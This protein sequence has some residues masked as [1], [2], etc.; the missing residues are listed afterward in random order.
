[1]GFKRRQADPVGVPSDPEQL[2]RLLARGNQGPAS[3]W[4]HQAKV[5]EHW[6]GQ[7]RAKSDVALEL[8]TGAGKTLV[9][10]LIAEYLRRTEGSRVAYLCP[11][12]QLAVQTARK[13]DDYGIPPS[14]LIG[15]S[16]EWDQADLARYQAAGS[17]AVSTYSHVFN[18]RPRIDTA[19]VLILDD[20]HAAEGYVSSPWSLRIKRRS[21]ESA[22]KDLLAALSP[23]LDP[24][25]LPHLQS[26]N[27]RGQYLTA[28]YLASPAA[29]AARAGHVESVIREAVAQNKV[30]DD[31]VYAWK[32]LETHVADCLA[33]VSYREILIRP[34]IAPTFQHSAFNSPKQRIYMSA[35]LGAGGE[36]ER[37]FGRPRIHRIPV[38]AGWD[39]EGTGRRFFVFPELAR[40]LTSD[41]TVVASFVQRVIAQA[42]RVVVLTPE[43]RVA[44][45][46]CE[47]YLPEDYRT[48]TA[49]EVE[50]DL[51]VFTSQP[52]AALVLTNRYDGVDLP[53]EDCRL[54]VFNGLP[55]NGDLQEKFLHD[56][57]GAEEVLRERIRARIQQGA[58]RATRNLRDHAA[59]LVL[60]RSLTSYLARRDIQASMHPEIH[61]ELELGVDAS[62]GQTSDD[63]WENLVIFN[64]QGPDWNE[65]EDD[66]IQNRE[67]YDRKD[68][69]GA[70]ALQQ[71]VRSEVA[72]AN[73]LW[74]KD[75]HFALTSI[76]NVTDQLRNAQTPKRYS[77]LWSY[78]GFCVAHRLAEA[79]GEAQF[80]RTA[81]TY[82]REAR[83]NSLGTTW[84]DRVAPVVAPSAAAVEGL[85]PTD[86]AA[87]NSILA[88]NDLWE[89]EAFQAALAAR[90]GLLETNPD[91]YEDGL[92]HLGRLAGATKSYGD[93]RDGRAAMPDAVWIFDS[94]RWVIWEAKNQATNTGEIGAEQARQAGGHR[95][96]TEKTEGVVAPGDSICVLA[97]PKPKVHEST[98]NVAEE[99]VYWVQPPQVLELFDTLTR[100]W[101]DARARNLQ[102]MSVAALAA[103]FREHQALPSQWLP[104]LRQHPLWRTPEE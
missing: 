101:Q 44:D 88:A 30:S 76:K 51:S 100:A 46:F 35:T 92:V 41:T 68:G 87:M 59:V 40:D 94:A 67:T 47:R 93:P 4:G 52:T 53:D 13:L 27:P 16:R 39:K 96:T 8:P 98:Y 66:I 80:Q 69:P 23:A 28:I 34:L 42:G 82:Y 14:L 19:D 31:A 43:T 64:D 71:A 49:K 62:L 12:R 45:K 63:V 74:S 36:L 21:H 78:L 81:D 75:H 15:P 79:T 38:P 102:T 33:Y 1:M 65:I 85:D 9:G 60:G 24:L 89:P 11:T 29:V 73:A 22:Y 6:H 55:A 103:V 77:S 84:F 54:V 58:G 90:A 72:A 50:E 70:A 18:S 5:M 17:V 104:A 26:E 91:S 99:N 97:S 10:G 3:V 7:F 37:A 25:L 20:A 32:F 48:F 61:A 56:S 57:V 95:R 2:Y 83:R 86:E